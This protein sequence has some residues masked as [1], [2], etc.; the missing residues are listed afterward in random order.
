MPLEDAT[1]LISTACDLKVAQGADA[2]YD[3]VV[4]VEVPKYLDKRGR[5]QSL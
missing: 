2:N 1:L 3:T 5:L 4:Y